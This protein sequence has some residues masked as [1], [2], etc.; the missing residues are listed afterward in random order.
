MT[1][2][3]NLKDQ[4][5]ND[6]NNYE[7]GLNGDAKSELH[8]T[9]KKAINSFAEKG[10][11]TTKLEDWKY[12]NLSSLAKKSFQQNFI[13]SDQHTSIDI[14]KFLIPNLEANI[15]VFENGWYREDL[16]NIIDDAEGLAI[17][18]LSKAFKYSPQ[19]ISQHF[20]K[21]ADDANEAMVALNTGL[22]Q[23]GLFVHI[24]D[25]HV[26]T[27]PVYVLQ[28]AN[29]EKGATIS[30]PRSLII[31]GENS[32][33]KVLQHF[34]SLNE[35]AESFSNSVIEIYANPSALVEHFILQDEATTATNIT[36][37]QT[38]LSKQ[39]HIHCHKR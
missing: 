15:L 16:S 7:S 25:N 39:S 17:G 22:A 34:V 27:H 12:T 18:N 35:T 9:R 31:A 8:L 10:F 2:Q 33:A 1:D 21:Y 36:E 26:L 23:D 13:T 5:V 37:T 11:P 30:S 28:I 29:T 20:T 38:Y 4:L 19:L 6:F 14:S 3:H 32:Q 24:P